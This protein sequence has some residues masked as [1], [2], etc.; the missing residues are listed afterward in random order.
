M[1]AL[2]CLTF[3]VILEPF[4]IIIFNAKKMERNPN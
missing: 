3:S 2:F 1:D 4:C